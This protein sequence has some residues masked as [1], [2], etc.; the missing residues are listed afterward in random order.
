MARVIGNPFGELRGK[1]AG[2]VFSRNAS[3]PIVRQYV[4]PANANSTAQNNSRNIFRAASQGYKTTSEAQKSDWKVFATGFFTPQTKI[5]IGQYTGAQ[6]FT[7]LRTAVTNANAKTFT[8]LFT[9]L[10]D[11]SL[12]EVPSIFTPVD[13][14]PANSVTPDLGQ[15]S[16]P[17]AT[18]EL[19]S[20]DCSAAGI[21]DAQVDIVGLEH[22]DNDADN[23][24]DSNGNAYSFVAYASDVISSAGNRPKNDLFQSLGGP[25]INTF[26]ANTLAGEDGVTM[27]WDFSTLISGF[28]AWGSVDKVVKIT[29]FVVAENGTMARL[30][31]Q[32][33]TLK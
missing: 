24:I 22:G 29:M 3:G 14:A 5:N 28:K 21:L 2:S 31:D 33:V 13:D 20:L 1:L 26:T 19:V 16:G 32:F 17:P 15:L 30:G 11:Q 10:S 4:I 7:S 6:A 9:T 27:Q 8:T 25:A 12:T 18:I 23:F